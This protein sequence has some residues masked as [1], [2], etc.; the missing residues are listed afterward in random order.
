MNE[1]NPRPVIKVGQYRINLNAVTF[2]TELNDVTLKRD[3]LGKV[4]AASIVQTDTFKG[5]LVYVNFS[6]SDDNNSI[7]LFA[8][9]AEKFLDLYDLYFTIG[10][11]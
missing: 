2:V 7:T 8:E 4:W 10:G 11:D 9:E 6:S 1:I 5:V 3:N